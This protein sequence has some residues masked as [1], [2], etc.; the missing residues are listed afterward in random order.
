M[1]LAYNI[2]FFSIFIP[3]LCGIVCLVLK[4]KASKLL[5][6]LMLTVECVLLTI[7]AVQMSVSGESFRFAMGHFPA[8]FGN[9]LRAGALEALMACSFGAVTLFSLLGGMRDIENDVPQSKRS[10]LNVIICI[11]FTALMVMA[12]TNDMF[13]SFVFIDIIT[14]S[15][16]SLVMIKPGGR[17]LIATIRYLIMSLVGSALYL[18]SLSMLYNISGHL[19]MEPIGAALQSV[20]AGGQYSMPLF[21]IA[22]AMVTA[23]S[24]KSAVFPFHSWLPDAHASATTTASAVLSGII[25]KSYLF[26]MIKIFY[27]VFGVE[28]VKLLQISNI[29]LLFGVLGLIIGSVQAI[30][31]RD[32]KRMLSYSSV[33]QIGYICIAIGLGSEAGMVA[34]CFHIIAHALSKAMLFTAAGGLAAVSG[35]SKDFDAIRG[36]GRR[37]KTAGIAFTCG[38][39]SMVGIPLFSGFISKL[40]LATAAA[41]TMFAGVVIFT[42]VVLST[43]LSSMYYF[44]AIACIF[45]K[46]PEGAM[47]KAINAPEATGTLVTAGTIKVGDTIETVKA[48][49]AT[50]TP[51]MLEAPK[52]ARTIKTTKESANPDGMFIV[53]CI[54]FIILNLAL[55]IFSQ[56]VLSAISTGLSVLG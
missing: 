16:C 6:L 14:I 41:D 52:M 22:A 43:V 44:P 11:L 12:F 24:I 42:A 47:D 33:A 48:R 28:L 21:I 56:P 31:Q 46:R 10:L 25:I 23:L 29:L 15:A 39:L 8:P 27:R 1:I 53:S 34:A 40:Y 4:P 19:L 51:N 26:L 36:S 3:L 32:I 30:R 13:T 45:S 49:E 38:A 2:P 17:T 18:L 55:G 5:T 35:G 37:N 50:E 7:L 20:T 9:E 54:A